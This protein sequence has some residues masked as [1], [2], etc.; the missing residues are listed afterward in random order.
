MTTIRLTILKSKLEELEGRALYINVAQIQYFY[1]Y[2]KKT[3]PLKGTVVVLGQKSEIV[4][5]EESP[6]RIE[7]L[8]F[9]AEHAQCKL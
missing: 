2:P 1:K 3:P 8:I 5:V 7:E 4:L 6:E 9:Q